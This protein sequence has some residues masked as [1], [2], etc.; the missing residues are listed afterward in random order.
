M[1][2]YIIFCIKIIEALGYFAPSLSAGV[3]PLNQAGSRTRGG[4]TLRGQ[5]GE[6]RPWLRFCGKQCLVRH[7]GNVIL[8]ALFNT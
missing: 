5:A 7:E 1:N 8:G 6:E 2:I 4:K 3:T